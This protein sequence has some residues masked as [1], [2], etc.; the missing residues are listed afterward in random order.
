[1]RQGFLV[2]RI[3]M[4]A[5][6]SFVHDRQF[7]EHN[8]SIEGE[9][10]EL[11][12]ILQKIVQNAGALLEVRNCSVALLDVSGTA[13]VTL[14][15]VA[16]GRIAAEIGVMHERAKGDGTAKTSI[17]AARAA[18]SPRSA[19]ATRPGSAIPGR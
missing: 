17:S 8:A 18:S 13:L 3:L 7:V 14:T 10:Q 4:T 9:S 16:L 5:N 1:M 6:M 15:I 2:G 11:V 12:D 19:T